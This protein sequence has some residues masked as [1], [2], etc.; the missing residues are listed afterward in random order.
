MNKK[1][2][3]ASKQPIDLNLV[4]VYKIV[5][6]SWIEHGDKNFKYFIDYADGDSTRRLHIKLPH[7]SG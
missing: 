3:N 4:D 7:M 1:K 6:T 2:F 5:I